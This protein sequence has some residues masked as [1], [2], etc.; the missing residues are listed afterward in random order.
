MKELFILLLGGIT[1]VNPSFSKHTN[2]LCFFA[3]KLATTTSITYFTDY[4]GLSDIGPSYEKLFYSQNTSRFYIVDDY[5]LQ[6]DTSKKKLKLPDNG[7]GKQQKQ[8]IV[9]TEIDGLLL[10]A[11]FSP[12][13]YDFYLFFSQNWTPPAGA[14]GY[15]LVVKE[16]P[17]RG[18]NI[19]VAIEVN[20]KQLVYR[21][22][23]PIYPAINGLAVAAANYLTGYL[24]RGDH[25]KGV[26]AD[27]N[28]IDA[29][30]NDVTRRIKTPF[31]IY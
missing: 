7:Q 24:A 29:Q 16:Y 10:D 23:R 9:T 8:R 21:R 4:Q 25:L 1:F 3:E 22:M 11:T 26:D 18:A 28:F 15:T 13:G 14:S 2:T 5:S 19:V 17:G 12:G 6:I 27:G 30:Q 31:D 20:G